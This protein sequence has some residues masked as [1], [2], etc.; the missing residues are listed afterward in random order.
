[1]TLAL[2]NPAEAL[3]ASERALRYERPSCLYVPGRQDWP[4]RD[5]YQ[6]QFHQSTHTVR[7]L[8][9]GNGA[10][11]TTTA[12]V[13]VDWWVQHNHP[14]QPTPK[15]PVQVV[16]VCQ[17]FQQMDLLREQL[18]RRCF[19]RGW[20]WNENKHRYEWRDGSTL[21]VISND[22]DWASIQGINPDLVVPDEECDQSLWRELTMRR[23]GDKKTRFVIPATATHG[24]R[25]MYKEIYV[26]WLTHHVNAGLTE[27]QA[28][29]VQSH[30]DYWVWP[31]GGLLDNP[32]N[33]EADE[34]WYETAL[35]YAS[36]QERQVRLRGGFVDLN[37]SPVFDIAALDAIEQRMKAEGRNG[38]NG[39]LEPVTTPAR[40][41]A[42]RLPKLQHHF[43]FIPNGSDH[44]G[45]RITVYE[46]PG[47]H[48]YVIGADFAHGL[49]TGDFDAAV[50]LRRGHDN[51]VHQ[52]A[53]AHGRWGTLQFTF[54]LYALGWYFNEALIVGEAN[55]MGLGVL[56]RLY[57]EL[58]Y[59]YQYFRET[60]PDAKASPRT[61]RLGFFKTAESK[62]IPR[63]QWAINPIDMNSG[64]R[65]T[66][67]LHVRS[68]HLLE[69]LRRYERRPRNKTADLLGTRDKDLVMGA[70]PGYHDDL[71]SACAA[72]VTGW[73]DLAR[74]EKPEPVFAAGSM[75]DVL[76]HTAVAKLVKTYKAFR[77]AK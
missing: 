40:V 28:M 48:T 72:A 5:R 9:L 36:P 13:E 45:G 61:D 6:L 16:W 25:W 11:K 3:A 20:T 35:A 52:V 54:V 50:V 58:D 63:L 22:G 75:G 69:E 39:T 19:T 42:H 7:C 21:T 17:K 23:R 57:S 53:E 65:S 26:P 44:E 41:A 32:A 2:D 31:K 74:F 47:D 14:Y 43:D 62:L 15:G 46:A 66:S 51:D 64:A 60:R 49:S 77:Y 76:G 73:F 55:S 4:E 24:K 27:D 34:R 71:V 12:G 68:P 29:R 56:Q 18:E 30:P 33:S 38:V 8:V 70:E 67:K 37:Q 1:M 10:G 59:T